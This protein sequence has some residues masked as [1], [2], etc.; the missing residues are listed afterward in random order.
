MMASLTPEYVYAVSD[1]E[2]STNL[3]VLKAGTSQID[4][5]YY[6]VAIN[7]TKPVSIRS[8]NAIQLG[9]LD[10]DSPIDEYVTIL[11]SNNNL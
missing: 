10:E 5:L 4:E 8:M 3:L 2:S 1:T 7:D 11:D 6:S 9:N